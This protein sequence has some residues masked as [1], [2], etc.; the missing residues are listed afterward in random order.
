MIPIEEYKFEGVIKTRSPKEGPGWTKMAYTLQDGVIYS[1]FEEELRGFKVGDHIKGTYIKKDKYNN[2]TGVE[3]LDGQ[4]PVSEEFVEDGNNS[5][6]SVP[7]SVW[8]I[9][10]RKIIRQHC[11]TVAVD[12]L[13]IAI[14][15]GFAPII[16]DLASLLQTQHSIAKQLENWIYE[17]L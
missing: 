17:N 14:D 7:Q 16:T 6:K 12:L 8:D 13:K 11:D 3:L 9:K 5:N 1:T 15:K 2:L 10:D 4:F